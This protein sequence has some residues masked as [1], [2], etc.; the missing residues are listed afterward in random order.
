MKIVDGQSEKI[1]DKKVKK[2][3]LSEREISGSQIIE[4]FMNN[5]Y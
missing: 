5:K 2:K 4:E 1:K 3:E